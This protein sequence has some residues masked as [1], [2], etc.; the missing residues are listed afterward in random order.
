MEK[1]LKRCLDSVLISSILE[2]IEIIIVNDGSTDSSLAIMESY[3]AQFPQSII[4][5]NKSNGG[6]GSCR[7]S[8]LKIACGRYFKILDAD[9]WFESN[10]FVKYV[11]MLERANLDMVLTNYSR[12]FASGRSVTVLS[13]NDARDIIPGEPHDFS[14]F[15]LSNDFLTMHSIT[16][17]TRLLTEIDLKFTEGISY[18]DT[19]Y[20]FYPLG[21]IKS[22][23][24]LNII[25]YK[26]Y[27]GRNGQSISLSSMVRNKEHFY[28]LIYR[29]IEYLG[30]NNCSDKVKKF[31]YFIL[32]SLCCT[33]YRIILIFNRK[34]KEDD[35]KLKNIDV[36]I[37]ET[38][39]E[40]Y[41]RIEMSRYCRVHF[42]KIWREEHQYCS[43][44]LFYKI[45]F[46][47]RETKLVSLIMNRE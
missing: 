44:M 3:K 4:V 40:L 43:Q 7:N 23:T 32:E 45:L 13:E 36:L 2:K 31:R 20:I 29:M 41:R 47:M 27:I 30:Q 17:R 34:S 46:G 9:D 19:E 8:A 15:D 1:Y 11:G 14:Q 10:A 42:V 18:T 21:H 25:L 35:T 38:S 33:Y 16:Y 26:Y 6:A 37:K 39:A 28:L 5:I 22:Y 24:Y 12:E